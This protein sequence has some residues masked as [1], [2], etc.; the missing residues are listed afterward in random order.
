MFRLYRQPVKGEFFVVFGDA[1]QGGS[2]S[3]YVQFLSKTSM[4]FPLVF[5]MRGVAAEANPY[6][7]QAL[8]WIYDQTQVKPV[9]AWERQMGGASEM[10][11][12]NMTN[13]HGKFIL[14]HAKKED[15]ENK[16]TLGWDT[17]AVTRP[18]MLG[19]WLTAFNSGLFK[20]YDKDTIDQHK[21]FIVNKRNRPEAA[22]NTHDDAVMSC[23]GAYQLYQTENPPVIKKTT[24][25]KPKKTRFHI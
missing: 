17:N 14:Y 15:D 11:N 22:P 20:I 19:E 9:F 10:H 5:K 2:D 7:R 18:N 4:D 21:T 12:L 8:E 23:A 1:A 24:R 25:P 16:D 6:V 13:Q 3:N